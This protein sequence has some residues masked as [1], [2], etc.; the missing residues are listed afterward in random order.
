MSFMSLS[1]RKLNGL[2]TKI[3]KIAS[4]KKHIFFIF[5]IILFYNVLVLVQIL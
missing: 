5:L 2:S 1:S 3:T 4:N